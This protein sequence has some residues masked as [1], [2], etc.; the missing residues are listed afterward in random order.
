MRFLPYVLFVGFWLWSVV[1]AG[2]TP[3]PR[4][5]PRWSWVLLTIFAPV[6][7]GLLWFTTGRP[8]KQQTPP[9]GPDDDQ[10]FLRSL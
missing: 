1:E 8:R 5:M 7:G 9:A 6:V 2:S 4:M 3:A 10:D